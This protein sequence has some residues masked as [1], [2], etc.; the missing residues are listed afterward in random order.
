MSTEAP[1]APTIDVSLVVPFVNSVRDSFKTMI[2]VT[3]TIDRPTFSTERSPKY[4]VS[5][6]IGFSGQVVGCMVLSFKLETA[7]KLVSRFAGCPVDPESS[8]FSDG[9]GEFTNWIAGAAKKH[10]GGVASISCP[11]VIIGTGH[12]IARLSDVPC[13]V[14][15]CR[16]EEGEFA[17]EVSIKK[18]ANNCGAA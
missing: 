18:A 3:T 17:I 14:I 5:G 11:G 16:T 12:S 8:D 13:I 7:V 2:G 9:V 1:A 4:E 15:P 10:L 6:I